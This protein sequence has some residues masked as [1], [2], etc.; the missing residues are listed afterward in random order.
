MPSLPPPPPRRRTHTP[1]PTPKPDASAEA[2]DAW[3]DAVAREQ[4]PPVMR[5][6]DIPMMRWH[7][8]RGVHLASRP[9]S[10]QVNEQV[11]Q[12]YDLGTLVAA[13]CESLQVYSTVGEAIAQKRST[14]VVPQYVGLHAIPPS[15]YNLAQC[16]ALRDCQV[17][18]Q[19]VSV[20][21]LLTLQENL[22]SLQPL[23]PI[24]HR[25]GQK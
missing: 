24:N 14:L 25:F 20:V 9:W 8:R 15:V 19:T 16:S 5:D 12:A 13:C 2:D 6:P 7:T 4:K 1:A 11:T 21:G 23:S 3:A 22:I 17:P 18:R 10:L